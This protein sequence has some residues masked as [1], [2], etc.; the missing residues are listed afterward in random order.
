MSR[1]YRRK[2]NRGWWHD[3]GHFLS[4]WVMSEHGFFVVKAKISDGHPEYKKRKAYF[5]SD[6]YD[7]AFKEPGPS[8]F[9]NLFAERKQRRTAKRELKKFMMNEDHEVILNEKDPLPYWT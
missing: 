8:W 1:T 3:E 9:R 4:D 7:C 2:R 5:H 6:S